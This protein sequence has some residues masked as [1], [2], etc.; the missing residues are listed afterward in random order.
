VPP[1]GD[2]GTVV[3]AI[4][5]TDTEPLAPLS[6]A[7]RAAAPAG[8]TVV[9]DLGPD[10]P[11]ALRRLAAAYPRVSDARRAF[12]LR[13]RGR[14]WPWDGAL[15]ERLERVMGE[16]DLLDDRGRARVGR[17]VDPYASPTLR[18]A[19]LAR[20]ALESLATLLGAL[21]REDAERAIAGLLGPSLASEPAPPGP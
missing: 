5:P 11:L 9:L 2:A 20:H 6:S 10:G 14:P 19:L 8:G 1:G 7:L 18:A 12:V 21:P 13:K 17:R 16:L 4:E 15:A 3:R